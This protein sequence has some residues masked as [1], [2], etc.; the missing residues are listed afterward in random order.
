[1]KNAIIR[2]LVA[3]AAIALAAG[4]TRVFA[5]VE[6]SDNIA[7][8]YSI[9]RDK[10][11]LYG[12]SSPGPTNETDDV[13]YIPD[14]LGGKPVVEI[15]SGI[16]PDW[17]VELVIPASVTSVRAF[18]INNHSGSNRLE[19]ITVDSSNGYY[20]SV[21]GCLYTKDGKTLM[22]C[23]QGRTGTVK[24]AEGTLYVSQYAFYCCRYVTAVELPQGLLSIGKDA[25]YS[26]GALVSVN[27]PSTVRFIDEYA[28]YG[29]AR[30]TSVTIPN[31][32]QRIGDYT[33]YGCANLRFGKIP[34]SVVSIGDKAFDGVKFDASDLPQNLI[35]IPS[36][37]ASS[38]KT[39]T[40][41]HLPSSIKYIGYYAFGFCENLETI[42]LNEGL[43]EIAGMAFYYVKCSKLTI[44]SSV[45]RIG[46]YSKNNDSSRSVFYSVGYSVSSG[47]KLYF[48]GLPPEGFATD[49][50]GSNIKVFYPRAYEEQWSAVVPTTA[51]CYGGM[52]D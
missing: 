32:V 20:K 14:T 34:D 40:T 49:S 13:L 18:S 51:A 41:L 30:L 4:G 28:F 22:R 15:E 27:V 23:P 43:E 31:G 11:H 33:F 37:W 3:Y 38:D 19:R 44:P 2:N 12:M 10:V 5:D 39:L 7:W 9:V 21:D 45:K 16:S 24:V 1:M 48:K 6:Y 47:G 50:I 8:S 25:F 29:C 46:Y 42:E 26:C 36:Y 52:T 17:H 35:E